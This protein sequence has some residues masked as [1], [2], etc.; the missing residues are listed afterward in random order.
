MAT[1]NPY[2]LSYVRTL[3]ASSA[4]YADGITPFNLG[5][6]FSCFKGDIMA[7]DVTKTNTVAIPEY[8]LN[9]GTTVGYLPTIGV[10][11]SFIYNAINQNGNQRLPAVN[12]QLN[13]PIQA[14]T[15]VQV[16]VITDPFAIYRIQSDRPLGLSISAMFKYFP[17]GTTIVNGIGGTTYASTNA[18]YSALTSVFIAP[19]NPTSTS[20]SAMTLLGTTAGTAYTN[21][22]VSPPALATGNNVLVRVIGLADGE[23]WYDA[24]NPSTASSY[25]SVLVQ[26]VNS[27]LVRAGTPF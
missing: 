2:G 13:T 3:T 11:N 1:F 9:G 8:L 6:G 12:Y 15:N 7:I 26:V 14:G 24:S 16:N 22:S 17:I 10:A 18:D 19:V 21:Q 23:T 4:V 25:N 27:G 20:V 5:T